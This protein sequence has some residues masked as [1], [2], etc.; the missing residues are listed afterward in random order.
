MSCANT[1]Y[2]V[3]L[4]DRVEALEN[5]GGM[6]II[7]FGN[8][9]TVAQ[10]IVENVPLVTATSVILAQM[11]IEDT[12]SHSSEDMLID[13]IRVHVKD[14]IAGVGFTIYAEM[15]NAPANGTYKVNWFL[16]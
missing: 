5:R 6:S 10:V 11:R 2:D 4:V 1:Y 15:D 7:D 9:N 16:A 12:T 8:S 14:I 3:P 13:P